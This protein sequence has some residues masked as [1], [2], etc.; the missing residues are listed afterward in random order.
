MPHTLP[1]PVLITGGGFLLPQPEQ[2]PKRAQPKP[3]S[4]MNPQ[5]PP[6]LP[7]SLPAL[8]ATC[9]RIVAALTR[10]LADSARNL[11][12][13][14]PLTDHDFLVPV[15]HPDLAEPLRRLN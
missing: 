8:D 13:A 4:N 9:D 12:H 3:T 11:E 5:P 2:V 10:R 1:P 15:L 7:R 6:P 14:C